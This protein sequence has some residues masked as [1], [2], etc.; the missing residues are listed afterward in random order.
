MLQNVVC[1]PLQ[2]WK[3]H[4]PA[5]AFELRSESSKGEMKNAVGGE[6]TPS[7]RRWVRRKQVC[8]S[9]SHEAKIL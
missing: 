2:S 3:R 5:A 4:K 6:K 9:L 8:V 1:T 7:L